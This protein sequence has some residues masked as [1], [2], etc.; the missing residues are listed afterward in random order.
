MQRYNEESKVTVA[1][2]ARDDPGLGKFISK[3]C[4]LLSE[5]KVIIDNFL[6]C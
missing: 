5:N 6:R 2:A 1:E 4:K 3:R